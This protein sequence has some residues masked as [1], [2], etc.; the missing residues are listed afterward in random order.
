MVA[1]WD[2]LK[3]GRARRP[4]ESPHQHLT[5]LVPDRLSGGVAQ[6]LLTALER[7]ES[8]ERR[9]ATLENRES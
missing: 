9:V 8:L 3:Y 1:A 7:I 5:R 6:E 4:D 2:A